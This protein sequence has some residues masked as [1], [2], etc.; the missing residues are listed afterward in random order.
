MQCT[1]D[2]DGPGPPDYDVLVIGAGFGGLRLLHELRSRGFSV[3]V[4]EAG[5][6]VGGTWYWNRYPGARTDSESWVYCYSFD[7]EL[8]QEWNWS[9]RFSAQPEIHAYL[10]HVADRFDLR[11]DIEVNTRVVAA[12]FDDGANRWTVRTESGHRRSAAFLIPA[13]GYFSVPYDPP[14]PGLADFAGEWYQSQRWPAQVVDFAG[15]RVGVVGTGATGVQIIPEVAHTAGQLTVFQRTP[16]YVIPSRNHPLESP[17]QQAIKADYAAVWEQCRRQVFAF[18]IPRTGRRAADV[19][20]ADRERILEAGWERGGFRFI[21]ETFDDVTADP[22][23]NAAAA[24]FVRGK[25]RSIVADPHTA[26]LL[27]PTDHPIGTK[28]I[29]LGHHYYETFNRANV[30]LVSIKNNAIAAITARGVLLADGTEHRLDMLIFALGF[31]AATGA[32]TRMAVRGRAGRD[33]AQEWSSGV[34][35]YLGL[36]VE[37]FPNLLLLGGPHCPIL[38][39]PVLIEHQAKWIARLLEHLRASGQRRI[40]PRSTAVERWQER[41]QQLFDATLLGDAVTVGSYYVGANIPGK[42]T[43]P[44]FYFGGAPKYFR[45]IDAVADAGYDGFELSGAHY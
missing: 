24:D 34:R 32:L 37:G 41:V 19:C 40:E 10:S 28:R 16:T 13:T 45:E 1:S 23:S 2:P 6:D 22:A 39:V 30:E 25:I 18:P 33:L 4:L 11:K 17:Q 44:L 14:F 3:R 20:A 21:F 42:S 31:D 15:K 43:G 8:A 7:E 38:N 36:G 29:P 27:C 35:T 5:S 9:A 12:E 26:E